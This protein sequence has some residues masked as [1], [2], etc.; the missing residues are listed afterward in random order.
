[1]F[2][3]VS[4]LT[5]VIMKIIFKHKYLGLVHLFVQFVDIYI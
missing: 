2:G 5:V 3:W 4:Q 1:M